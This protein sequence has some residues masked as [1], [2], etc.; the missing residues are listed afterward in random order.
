MRE[1]SSQGDAEY[2]ASQIRVLEDL[3]A[4]RLRPGMYIGSTSQ[5]GMH[6]L[7]YEVVDNAVDEA[8]AGHA[9][10]VWVHLRADGSVEVRDNGRGIPIERHAQTG[11]SSLETVLTVLHAGGKFGGEQ[12]GYSVSGGLHGVGISV[13]NALSSSMEVRVRRGD[14]NEYAQSFSRGVAVSD[15]RISDATEHPAEGPDDEYGHVERGTIVSFVPDTEI[16]G[17]YMEHTRDKSEPRATG[18]FSK[19]MKPIDFDTILARIREIAFLNKGIVFHVRGPGDDA[20]TKIVYEGGLSEYVEYMT[21]D[22]SKVH[23]VI[24]F[25]TSKNDLDIECAMVWCSE[26]YS[27]T[28]IGYANSVRTVDGGTHVDGLKRGLSKVVNALVTDLQPDAQVLN[29]MNAIESQRRLRAAAAEKAEAEKVVVVK[30][31][32]GEAEAKFLSG[33]GSSLCGFAHVPIRR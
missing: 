4:V 8:Q 13:V 28:V 22:K 10:D 14:G 1:V 2:G 29:A 20:F 3:E 32:E 21:Q 19:A 15:I 23:D 6:H 31:A 9:T 5:R 27:S 17:D 26:S 16:F 12:S 24:S 30:A 33:Q 18:D 25:S 11:K 7:V